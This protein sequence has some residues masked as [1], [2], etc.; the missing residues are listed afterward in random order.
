MARETAEAAHRLG[1]KPKGGG[2]LDL[3]S[4]GD[5]AKAISHTVA[6]GVEAL[7]KDVQ[8]VKDLPGKR[9]ESVSGRKTLGKPTIGQL[10][11]AAVKSLDNPAGVKGGHGARGHLT[12]SS[13]LSSHG[14]GRRPPLQIN[15]N[16]KITVPATRRAARNLQRARQRLAASGADVGKL[17]QRF[18]ELSPARIKA[19]ADAERRSGVPAA[20]LAAISGVE[21][22]YGRSTLPGVHSGQNFAG[23]AGPFQ[24]GNGTGASG[25]AWAEKAA[26]RWGPEADRHSIYNFHDA[27]QGAGQYLKD[28]GATKDPSTWYNAALS[29]NHADWYAQEVVKSAQQHL[30]LSA[31]SRPPDPKA[32]AALAQAK[33]LAQRLGIPTQA[34]TPQQQHVNYLKVFGQQVGRELHLVKSGQYDKGPGSIVVGGSDVNYGHE[35][36]IAARLKLLSAKIGKPIY[37]ISG[38]RTPQHSVEVGGFANDP[39]TEGKAADIGVGS[40]LRDSAGT[41]SEAEYESVGLHRPYYPA[42][43][44]EINHVELLNGGTPATGGG[45]AIGGVSGAVPAIG[46]TGGGVA[47]LGAA[48]GT[49]GRVSVAGTTGLPLSALLNP[50]VALPA[51]YQQFQEGESP[52]E[53]GSQGK[54]IIGEILRRKRL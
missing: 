32:A 8:V 41:I 35:P 7:A 44:T 42:S 4:V 29:Y 50:A 52:L 9:V 15:A 54:G 12:T 3:S 38:H 46:G 45:G 37:V 33:T 19:L 6:Q 36:E 53:A 40:A 26:E 10:L 28:A 30:G 16:G 27:A 49:G 14:S 34:P 24:I 51:A 43:A 11:G 1:V 5:A 17:A 2:N 22:D 21:S 18:P 39:H 25:N 20:L 23:A 48:R 31:A 47:P 13:V